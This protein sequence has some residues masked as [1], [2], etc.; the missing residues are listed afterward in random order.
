MRPPILKIYPLPVPW[1]SLD[2]RILSLR[3]CKGNSAQSFLMYGHFLHLRPASLSDTLSDWVLKTTVRIFLQEEVSHFLSRVHLLYVSTASAVLH[4]LY[5]I[6]SMLRS[7]L[8]LTHTC[9]VY[10]LRLA[11]VETQLVLCTLWEECSPDIHLMNR[12][13][14]NVFVQVIKRGSSVTLFFF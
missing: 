8:T 12:I 5:N 9:C 13:I 7:V 11:A 4:I 6:V 3:M 10:F 1:G 2:K 14:Q